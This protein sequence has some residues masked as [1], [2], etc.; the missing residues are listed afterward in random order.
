MDHRSYHFFRCLSLGLL[1][2]ALPAGWAWAGQPGGGNVPTPLT[3]SADSG[4]AVL[5][6]LMSQGGGFS[7]FVESKILQNGTDITG[8]EICISPKPGTIEC[9]TMGVGNGTWYN[10]LNPAGQPDSSKS[11][12]D[13]NTYITYALKPKA[14]EGEALIRDASGNAVDYLRY[15]NNANACLSSDF[16]WDVPA[17]CSECMTTRDANQKNLARRNPDGS[18]DWVNN[19]DNPTEGTNNDVVATPQADH[20]AIIHDGSGVNCQ[21]EP[22]TIQAHDAVHAVMTDY[23]ADLSLSTSTGHGTWSIGSGTGSLIDMGGGSA[24]Y[25]MVGTD[26]GSATLLLQDTFVET[27]SI[28]VTDGVVFE[29]AAADPDLAFARAGFIYQVNGATAAIPGQISGKASDEGYNAAVLELAAVNTNDNTGACEAVFVGSENVDFALECDDPTS[30]GGSAATINATGIPSNDNGSA[31]AYQAI[32]LDFGDATDS[33]AEFV[34]EYPDAGQVTL[35]AKA[36]P[37]FASGEILETSS[38]FIVRPFGFDIEITTAAGGINPAATGPGG[39]IFTAAGDELEASLRA[40]AWQAAD[41]TDV[42]GIPDAY[43]DGDPSTSSAD[44]SDNA[45]TPN[46]GNEAV[47]PTVNLSAYI[48]QPAVIPAIGDP[49]L[50]GTTPVSTFAGGTATRNSIYIDDVGIYE[51]LA[52]MDA[53]SYLGGE[54]A[55]GASGPVGR[56]VPGYFHVTVPTHGCDAA[57]GTTYS[58]QEIGGTQVTAYIN[59]GTGIVAQYYDGGATPV[60]AKDVALTETTG[61]DGVLAPATITASEFVQGVALLESSDINPADSGVTFAFNS[62]DTLPADILL[63]ASDSDSVTSS[64]HVEEGTEIRSGRFLVADAATAVTTDAQVTIQAQ[65]F[66]DFGGGSTG[67]DVN[68]DH[69]CFTP[70]VGDFTLGNYTAPLAPGDTSISA[71]TFNTG[72][73]TLTL[74]APGTGNEGSVDVTGNVPSWFEFD[75][76]GTGPELP[77]GTVNFFGIYTTEDGFIDRT[78]VVQ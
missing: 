19:G 21:G 29:D 3:C 5:N 2:T 55:W 38:T 25:Q 67:W 68:A 51:V 4:S 50:N 6:E 14:A 32:G 30:C 36:D 34:F 44:L 45:T 73:G 28:G 70:V 69:S 53:N 78:E 12:Y 22:V 35:H 26:N 33:T 20:F 71:I 52:N 8:W 18:G 61:A 75:W 74:S 7:G 43:S 72:S 24:I 66:Q 23:A 58:G 63:R 11:I 57:S 77:V 10:A 56:F 46:F 62:A 40:V 41:D 31:L 9:M 47:A 17:S 16:T 60:F 1:V 49:G 64:G 76:N 59:R 48:W 13:S 65:Y 42:N 54:D 39:T 27:I 37:G 15:D